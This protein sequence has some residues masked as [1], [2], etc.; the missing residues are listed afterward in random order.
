MIFNALRETKSS[1]RERKKPIQGRLLKKD[2]SGVMTFEL[3]PESW[4]RLAVRVAERRKIEKPS[5]LRET[6]RAKA[7]RGDG[8]V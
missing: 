5:K 2:L 1:R 4:V 6:A 7:L 3:Y 8:L